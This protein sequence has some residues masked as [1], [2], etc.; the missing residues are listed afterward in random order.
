MIKLVI[1]ITFVAIVLM[2]AERVQGQESEL[3][4]ED[5]NLYSE[6]QILN[7]EKEIDQLTFE[8]AEKTTLL[9]HL[10]SDKT[11]LDQRLL[12]CGCTTEAEKELKADLLDVTEEISI[13]QTEIDD[14]Q[15]RLIEIQD[16]LDEIY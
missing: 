7:L 13:V 5:H 6:I 4:D 16:R 8:I 2:V 11:I 15:E 14:M 3:M 1:K 10:H 9:T 12:A